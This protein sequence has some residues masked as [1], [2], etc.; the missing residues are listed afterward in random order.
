MSSDV[1]LSDTDTP[2]SAGLGGSDAAK[3]RKHNVYF[4]AR[5]RTN[6]EVDFLSRK[7]ALRRACVF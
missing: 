1:S 6:S 4:I 3:R 7:R 5:V 2:L